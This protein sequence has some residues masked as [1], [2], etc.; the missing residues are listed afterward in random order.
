M[1]QA[2]N[3]EYHYLVKLNKK[4]QIKYVYKWLKQDIYKLAY[5]TISKYYNIPLEPND[6]VNGFLSQVPDIIEKYIPN[7]ARETDFKKYMI[8]HISY[9]MKNTCRTFLTNQNMFQSTLVEFNDEL[10]SEDNYS[11]LFDDLN[12][13]N[14]KRKLNKIQHEWTEFE[15]KVWKE[16]IRKTPHKLICK[17][18]LCT[19]TKLNQTI[20]NIKSKIKPFIN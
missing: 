15:Q 18:L 4:Q 12:L 10:Y 5:F 8:I 13:N 17:K 6:L 16:L 3:K 1:N 11:S 9:K 19:S 2:N 20:E 7:L 14:F